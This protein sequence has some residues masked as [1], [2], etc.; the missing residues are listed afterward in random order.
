[1]TEE[2]NDTILKD[3]PTE[4]APSQEDVALAERVPS[5]GNQ[6]EKSS[7]DNDKRG[8]VVVAGLMATVILAVVALLVAGIFQLTTRWLIVCPKELPVND[9]APVLWKDV[10]SDKVSPK[11]LGVPGKLLTEA[12]LKLGGAKDSHNEAGPEKS[13]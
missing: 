5:N 8:R 3:Q 13:R 11:T 12:G 10:V 9:P 4:P 2:F 1:M 7:A 6:H